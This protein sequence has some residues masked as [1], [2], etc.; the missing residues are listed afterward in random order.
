M[1]AKRLVK[2]HPTLLH[3]LMHAFSIHPQQIKMIEAVRQDTK[4]KPNIK[5]HVAKNKEIAIREVQIDTL[6]VKVFTDRSGMEG[7]IGA[8][9]VLY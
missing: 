9:T 4:W 1:L 8:A 3:N 7:N 2:W 6:D 5:I